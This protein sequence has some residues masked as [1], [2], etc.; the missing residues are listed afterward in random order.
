MGDVLL[1]GLYQ[2]GSIN[3]KYD[4]CVNKAILKE[5]IAFGLDDFRCWTGVNAD[6]TYDD[7]GPATAAEDC[8]TTGIGRSAGFSSSGTM[9]V[10]KRDSQG[11]LIHLE[12][13]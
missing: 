6:S 4:K 7:Y 9:A 3:T 11:T 5:I 1:N 13:T 8:K 10:Y 2:Y 12:I